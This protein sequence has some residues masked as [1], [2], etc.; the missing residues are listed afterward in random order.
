MMQANRL[1]L[2]LTHRSDKTTTDVEYISLGDLIELKEG[3]IDPPQQ[4]VLALKKLLKG[5]A[6][7]VEID[8]YL[9][10]PFRTRT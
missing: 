5:A 1:Y 6:L 4:L 3:L 10:E 2:D 7:A 9:V 8:K